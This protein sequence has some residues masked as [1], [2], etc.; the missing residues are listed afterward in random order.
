MAEP[1]APAQGAK[2]GWL[3]RG[4][5]ADKPSRRGDL[6]VAVL[7]VAL[8][9]ACAMF[10]W[11]IFFNQD[12]FA[13]EGSGLTIIPGLGGG[14]KLLTPP[15]G[16]AAQADGRAE[17]P[18]DKLDL[19]ATGAT[20]EHAPD[21]KAE[22]PGAAD[23]PFPAAPP[24]FRVVHIENGRAMIEDDSGLFVVG[25]GDLLPDNSRVA[26]I[27]KRDGRPVLVTSTKQVLDVAP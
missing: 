4:T 2:R 20:P 15:A 23:Q 19:F 25:R 10:P 6:T 18:I 8:G 24:R 1:Q 11:Y 21:G 5:A 13:P 14:P 17:I 3:R 27:E 26:G 16:P 22:P 12:K 9:L 7:G